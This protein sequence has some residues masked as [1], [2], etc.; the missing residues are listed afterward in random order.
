VKTSIQELFTGFV[1]ALMVLAAV[2]WYGW[3][4]T[5]RME[6]AA[7]LVNHTERVR[8]ALDHLLSELQEIE[9]GARGF[10][11]T[12]DP[13]FLEPFDGGLKKV[14]EELRGL[15]Q[16]IRDAEQKASL[17]ALEPLIADRIAVA[18]RNVELRQTSGFEAARQDVASG[19]GRIV[20]DQIRVRFAQMDAREQALLDQR[21]AAA[22]QEASNNTLFTLVGTGLSFALLITVFALVVREN[23][24]RRQ[25]QAEID[26]FFALSLDMLCIANADGYFKRISP[27]FTQTLGWSTEEILA[28]P[29]L[30]FVHPDD[31]VATVR[32]VETL[33]K[34]Q[35]LLDFENRYQHKDGSWRVLS[36][37]AVPQPGGLMYCAGRDITE[38][39]R[40]EESLRKS[41]EEFR[42]L[43]ESMPQIVWATR[44]DGWNIYFNQQWVDYT[45]LTREESYGHGWNIPFHPDDQQRAW[46]AWQRATKNLDT[47]QLECR[48]R[49]ADG[50]YRW[51]LIRGIPQCNAN[52]EIQK[53]FGTCTD[54]EDI[55]EAEEKIARLNADL[56]HRAAQLEGANKELESFSY[57]VSHDLRAP[58]RHVQGYVQMLAAATEGQLSDKALRYLKTINDASVEMGQLIDDLLAFSRMGRA[59]MS[60]DSVEP[61]I[62]M[63]ETLRGLELAVQGRN[64]EWKIA[65]LPGVV[66]DRAMI[67]QVLV[68][69]VGNAVKYTRQR[70]PARIE[71]GCEGE[72]DG[73]LIFFVRDNGAGFDMQ[74]AHKLFGV[75]QRLH[76][77]DEFE[78]T[79]IGLATVRRIISRHGG[80][81]WAEG[82]VGEGA[83]FYFTLQPAATA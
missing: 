45:G 52:G 76:R 4:H 6:E 12:G 1:L 60:E 71:I 42:S 56:Q 26:R 36:W 25:T 59:E 32:V 70:D 33:G 7:V 66:G 27:A 21:S 23:R 82:K 73:R 78:G 28:R 31:S 8:D 80:R 22:R 81:V 61:D 67:R 40:A 5:V 48:L 75:F 72:K 24:L 58:L 63:K 13:K 69:L 29:F 14:P 41:E 49:R 47:Y 68:N 30:D 19:A 35:P 37:K 53:W 9:V 44:A 16:L 18:R 3:R 55:K 38:R 10:V 2:A 51:W 11:I 74:Y 54:I 15:E 57:S 43:A 46:D 17:A 39:K 20:M 50:V 79:G 83:A 64:I 34:G 65:P 62:L 77:A